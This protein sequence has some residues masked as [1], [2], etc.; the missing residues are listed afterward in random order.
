MEQV[1][2]LRFRTMG[3]FQSQQMY[4]YEIPFNII[5]SKQHHESK[6]LFIFKL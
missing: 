6:E 3:C 1:W 4:I 2:M 5:E